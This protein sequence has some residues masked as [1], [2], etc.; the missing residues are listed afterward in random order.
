MTHIH[1]LLYSGRANV[2]FTLLVHILPFCAHL[3]DVVV[4]PD[5]SCMFPSGDVPKHA[6]PGILFV[7]VH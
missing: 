4:A 2:H 7:H 5:T 1:A 6:V 3:I